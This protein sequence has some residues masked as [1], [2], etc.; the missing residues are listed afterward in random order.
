MKPNKKKEHTKEYLDEAASKI[1]EHKWIESE[2]AG[3]DLGQDACIDWVK[4]YAKVHRKE[5]IDKH[6]DKA[7]EALDK[8][9]DNSNIPK[10]IIKILEAIYDEIDKAKDNMEVNGK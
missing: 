7:E 9:K 1:L 2:K 8:L 10:E 4:K 6:L 3:K 5:F